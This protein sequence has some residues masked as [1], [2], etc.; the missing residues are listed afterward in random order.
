MAYVHIAHDCFIDDY[1][2]LAMP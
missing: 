2:S 1:V